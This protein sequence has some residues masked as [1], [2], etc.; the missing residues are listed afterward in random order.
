MP[1]LG[2]KRE[3]RDLFRRGRELPLLTVI[4]T[5]LGLYGRVIRDSSLKS[6]VPGQLF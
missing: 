5:M 1:V 3:R 4:I 6:G 2:G